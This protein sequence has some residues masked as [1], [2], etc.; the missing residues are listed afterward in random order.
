MSPQKQRAVPKLA[1][2]VKTYDL[3]ERFLVIKRA[4]QLF[5]LIPA[6]LD[7]LRLRRMAPRPQQT[8]KA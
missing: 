4:Q 3:T 7:E 2:N 1:E 5:N 8:F 6:Y